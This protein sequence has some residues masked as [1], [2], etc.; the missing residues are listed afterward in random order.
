MGQLIEEITEY[1]HNFGTLFEENLLKVSPRLKEAEA[2]LI[3][4]LII[5]KHPQKMTLGECI[6]EVAKA[7][8]SVEDHEISWYPIDDNGIESDIPE[9]TIKWSR[10]QII[11]DRFGYLSALKEKMSS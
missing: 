6:K 7:A 3:A 10:D 2:E 8:A 5:G 11:L 4:L 9:S 1:D